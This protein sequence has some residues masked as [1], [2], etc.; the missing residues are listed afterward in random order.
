MGKMSTSINHYL[1]DN[2]RF[3]DLFNGIFFQGKSVIHAENLQEASQ[4]YHEVMG[5]TGRSRGRKE[6]IRD[7][8]KQLKTGGILRVLALENQELTDYTMPFRCMQYDVMEYGKQLDELKKKNRQENH[9]ATMAEKICGL[10]RTDRIIPVYTI[11]LYHGEERWDG[12]RSL[13]DMMVFGDSEDSFKKNFKDYPMQLYCLNEAKDLQ[14]FHT[15]VGM[16]FQALQYRKDRAG[17]K[18]LL[19]QDCRYRQLDADTL[20]TMSVMLDMPSIWGERKKYMEKDNEN[21]EVYNMCQAVREWAEEERS[22]GADERTHAVVRN[23]LMRDMADEVIMAIAECDQEVI[24]EIRKHY[25]LI[26][27]SL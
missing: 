1:S 4:V 17:L 23:M 3:S 18:Q 5:E 14:I 6:R 26:K 20:E 9:L 13:S 12:P 21:R 24:D 2:R 7:I 15:E 8:C 27:G 16:L 11:C 25:N 10:K 22:I 19:Q